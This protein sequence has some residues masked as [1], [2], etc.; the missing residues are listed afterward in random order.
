MRAP[1][2][3]ILLVVV[4]RVAPQMWFD[5]IDLRLEL[6]R[7]A[8]NRSGGW[9]RR[10]HP[11]AAADAA[12]ACCDAACG[13][14][15]HK[16][17]RKKSQGRC[18]P[19][20]LSRPCAHACDTGCVAAAGAEPAPPCPSRAAG[21]AASRGRV[22]VLVAGLQRGFALFQ[23]GGVWWSHLRHVHE[24]LVPRKLLPPAVVQVRRERAEQEAAML[25]ENA[26]ATTG[27]LGAALAESRLE[28]ALVES[29]LEAGVVQSM[30]RKDLSAVMAKHLRPE[31]IDV[32]SARFGLDDGTPR[33]I[34][35]VGETLGIPYSTAKHL[36]FTSLTK[37]RKPHVAMALRDYLAD[38]P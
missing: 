21:D 11:A 28:A 8:T 5:D 13:E 36:L 26:L 4:A 22:A 31:E 37:M 30:L 10:G 9:C 3:S 32:I 35:Q 1:C 14:C 19:T 6:A 20:E 7:N 16:D 18:C 24:P 29:R 2:S 12:L 34:R 27:R 33:T 25:L 23:Q 38:T 17:C 15:V